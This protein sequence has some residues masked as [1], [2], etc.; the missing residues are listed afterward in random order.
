MHGDYFHLFKE[1]WPKNENF[2]RTAFNLIKAQLSKMLLSKTKE[3]WDKAFSEAK[4]I[5]LPF[6]RK[7]SLLQNIYNNPTYY[8]GYVTRKII[9]NLN[10][11]GTVFAEQNH[12]SIVKLLGD[13]MLGNIVEHLKSLMKRQQFL[14]NKENDSEARYLVQSYKYNP[15]LDGD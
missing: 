4:Q 9:G 3:E 11:N 8:S 10:L 5:L 12:S 2:G 7:L 1:N 14:C 15:D 6:P 13:N